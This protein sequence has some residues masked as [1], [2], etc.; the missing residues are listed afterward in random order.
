MEQHKN[1]T[2]NQTPA[3]RNRGG[4]ARGRKNYASEGDA[5]TEMPT[6]ASFPA[7]PTK[8][9]RNSP[10]PAS[11]PAHMAKSTNRKNIKKPHPSNVSTTPSDIK[12]S[13]RTPPP[14]ASIGLSSAAFASSSSFHSPAPDTLP[15]PTFS[16]KFTKSQSFAASEERV[17]MRTRSESVVLQPSKEPSPPASDPECLSPSPHHPPSLVPNQSH[18]SPLEFLFQ[19]ERA[20]KER[21]RRANSAN[22]TAEV[23]GP[24]SAP[25]GSRFS[26]S[27][28]LNDNPIPLK[29]PIRSAQR[30]VSDHSDMATPNTRPGAFAMPIHERIQAAGPHAQQ[31]LPQR[32]PDHTAQHRQY[33]PTPPQLDKSEQMKR[34]LGITASP[35]TGS[36]AST[37]QGPPG[38]AP[39]GFSVSAPSNINA[40]ATGDPVGVASSDRK[41][42]LENTLRQALNLP[43][44]ISS[45]LDGNNSPKSNPGRVPGQL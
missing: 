38:A 26:Q 23:D 13:Q 35:S 11:Q 18:D 34:L 28:G 33:L 24:L 21:L 36:A 31:P 39:S 7:T 2:N 40:Q 27:Q 37:A 5:L 10:A 19:A 9:N 45:G 16:A 44:S 29:L 4:K 12:P 32:G 1:T 14:S 41:N 20:K 15:R 22:T 6:P 3:R 43:W 30:G 17:L 25:A 8:S 42:L